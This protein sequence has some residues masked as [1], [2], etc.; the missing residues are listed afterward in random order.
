M[1][2]VYTPT[3]R[4]EIELPDTQREFCGVPLDMMA[5]IYTGGASRFAGLGEVVPEPGPRKGELEARR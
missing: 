1:I 4:A 2:T 3:A 5:A